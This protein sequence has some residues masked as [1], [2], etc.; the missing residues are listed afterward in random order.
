MPLGVMLAKMGFFWQ[1]QECEVSL[2]DKGYRYRM[3]LFV[4]SKVLG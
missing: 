4:T 1:G 2:F 3:E